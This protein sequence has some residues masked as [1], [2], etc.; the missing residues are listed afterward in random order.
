MVES[1][2][3][4]AGR[5]HYDHSGEGERV[6]VFVYDALQNVDGIGGRQGGAYQNVFPLQSDSRKKRLALSQAQTE[7]CSI[8]AGYQSLRRA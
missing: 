2:H 8:S 6:C 4:H 3:G 7:T 5:V 1:F